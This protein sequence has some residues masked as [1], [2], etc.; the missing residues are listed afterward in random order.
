MTLFGKVDYREPR[1]SET[2]AAIAPRVAVIWAAMLN[3]LGHPQDLIL[4][5]EGRSRP[6]R[7]PDSCDPTHINKV[8]LG[9]AEVEC[10]E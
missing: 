2:N 3:C 9:E 8:R 10:V 1:I 4:H 5:L 6:A 7:R